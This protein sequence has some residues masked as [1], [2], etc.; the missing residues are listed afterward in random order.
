MLNFDINTIPN[1]MFMDDLQYNFAQC[2]CCYVTYKV[3]LISSRAL[4]FE[5]H[6][7]SLYGTA[8]Y[9][10]KN[11]LNKC[12]LQNVA[13]THNSVAIQSILFPVDTDL[14]PTYT[15]I[16][17]W[18]DLAEY[19]YDPKGVCLMDKYYEITNWKVSRSH[20]LCPTKCSI[21]LYTNLLWIWNIHQ[22]KSQYLIYF[23]YQTTVKQ[24]TT[25]AKLWHVGC[26]K[27]NL[28]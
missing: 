23:T 7:V 19:L 4:P 1:Y 22:R 17:A 11:V 12:F 18:C 8:S 15:C 14:L 24:M 5:S 9:L 6:V 3:H 16:S 28:A 27:S 2:I 21:D 26:R 13:I 20:C 25:I 10:P